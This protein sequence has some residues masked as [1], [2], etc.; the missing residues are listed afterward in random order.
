MSI[1]STRTPLEVPRFFLISPEFDFPR[2]WVMDLADFGGAAWVYDHFDHFCKGRLTCVYCFKCDE[3]I[4]LVYCPTLYLGMGQMVNISCENNSVCWSGVFT[5]WNP[6]PQTPQFCRNICRTRFH[7][8]E[9]IILDVILSGASS[10]CIRLLAALAKNN[11]SSYRNGFTH[12]MTWQYGI[13]WSL[14][15]QNRLLILSKCG[16]SVIGSMTGGV[17]S[18]RRFKKTWESVK[19]QHTTAVLGFKMFQVSNI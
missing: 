4:W 18:W 14:W 15:I 17:S 10:Y 11:K 6:P 12:N 13:L 19:F 3:K 1:I 2:S 7:S 16:D 5:S 9:F 8:G